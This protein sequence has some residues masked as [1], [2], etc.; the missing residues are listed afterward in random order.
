MINYLSFKKGKK[1]SKNYRIETGVNLTPTKATKWLETVKRQ[2]NIRDKVVND[3]AKTIR[4]GA[5]KNHNGQTMVF[6]SNGEFRDGQHRAWAVVNSGI[7]I[8]VDVAYDVDPEFIRTIDIGVPRTYGDT[9]T[10]EEKEYGNKVPFPQQIGSAL[11]IIASYE[12]GDLYERHRK[13]SNDDIYAMYK[14]HPEI[15]ESAKFVCRHGN[16]ASGSVCTALH[17]LFTRVLVLREKAN[18]FFDNFITGENLTSKSPILTLRNKFISIRSNSKASLTQKFTISCLIKAWEAY[19]NGR[20]LA[21]I[22][23]NPE[24]LPKIKVRRTIKGKFKEKRAA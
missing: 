20:P 18:V 10:M 1:M 15:V 6:D 3:Y 21:S 11:A 8:K 5:W 14:K 13:L 12:N 24:S 7:S 9:L 19:K 2:R 4:E 16:L 22:I 23:Y 17:Y